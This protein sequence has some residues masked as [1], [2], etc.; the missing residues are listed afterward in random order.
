MLGIAVGQGDVGDL[1]RF[2][3]NSAGLF[4]AGCAL[5]GALI[6]DSTLRLGRFCYGVALTFESILLFVAVPLL[7][8]E[9]GCWIVACCRCLRIAKCH[10]EHLQRGSGA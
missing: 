10:G 9:Y 7:H 5:S 2:C 3:R 4:M 1:L 8:A 6:G